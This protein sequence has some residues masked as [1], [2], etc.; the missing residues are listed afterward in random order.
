MLK[1]DLNAI[2]MCRITQMR[3]LVDLFVVHE[4]GDKEG[5]PEVGYV[6]VRG[7]IEGVE[8]DDEIVTED[9]T[10]DEGQSE[11]DSDE[12]SDEDSDSMEYVPSNEEGDSAHD[13][14]FTDNEEEYEY[15]SRFGE[16]NSVPKVFTVA[17]GKDVV[18]SGLSNEERADSD[19]LE[20]DHM[21]GGYEV[22][23]DDSEEDDDD[24]GPELKLDELLCIPDNTPQGGQLLTAIGRD[25]NDQMLPI[26]YAVVEAKTK[27]SWVWF[28][29]HLA[30]NLEPE[31]I[32]KCTFMSD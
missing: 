15:D 17:K 23:A 26:A 24:G 16:M 21:V 5:F 2:E 14:H 8:V 27:D 3:H 6:D 28:L 1:G 12:D 7:V 19:E 4:I 22:E 11:G 18:T 13:I 9:V 20:V 25:S 29:R 10:V 32:A 31:K 30:D